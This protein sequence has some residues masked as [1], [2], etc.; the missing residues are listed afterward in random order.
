M[1]VC[2]CVCVCARARVR[3]CVY[4]CVYVCVRLCVRAWSG[5]GRRREWA[6]GDA[7]KRGRMSRIEPHVPHA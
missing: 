6:R 3:V 2:V 5:S 1:C 7:G 4:V